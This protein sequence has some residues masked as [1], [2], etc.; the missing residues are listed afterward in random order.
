MIISKAINNFFSK[1]WF[2][3]MSSLRRRLAATMRGVLRVLNHLLGQVRIDMGLVRPSVTERVYT[4]LALPSLFFFHSSDCSR[5]ATL[6]PIQYWSQ[7]D[8]PDDVL[9]ITDRWNCELRKAGLPPIQLYSRITALDYIRHYIP[10][11]ELPFSTAFHYALEADIFRIAVAAAEGCMWLDCD[12]MPRTSCSELLKEMADR[13]ESTYFIWKPS[14]T[15]EPR[16][17]NMFFNTVP[18]CNIMNLISKHISNTDF[19]LLP[20]TKNTIAWNGGPKLYHSIIASF[21]KGECIVRRSRYLVSASSAQ[22]LVNFIDDYSL[23][24]AVKA[25]GLAYTGTSMQWQIAVP[26]S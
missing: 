14:R 2:H 17:S 23:L 7:G 25:P 16:I 3:S 22:G 8:P 9:K 1:Y 19:R 21:L 12:L 4:R 11:L 20:Q 24:S 5:S 15:G 18:M 10:N 26:D 6:N 13:L